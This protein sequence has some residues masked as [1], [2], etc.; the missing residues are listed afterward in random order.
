MASAGG[1][2]YQNSGGLNFSGN[3]TVD[4]GAIF[5]LGSTLV[6]DQGSS[7][8]ALIGNSTAHLNGYEIQAPFGEIV[9]DAPST[10]DCSGGGAFQAASYMIAGASDCPTL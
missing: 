6:L 2:F 8:F 10:A 3:F 4:T 9:T 7:S 1:L 5:N